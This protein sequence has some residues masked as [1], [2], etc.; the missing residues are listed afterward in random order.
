[1]DIN[2]RLQIVKRLLKKYHPDLCPNPTLVDEYTAV[3]RRLLKV[4][5]ELEEEER[6]SRTEKSALGKNDNKADQAYHCYKLGVQSLRVVHPGRFY[7]TSSVGA[8]T[9]IGS[10]AQAKVVLEI[11]SAIEESIFFFTQVLQCFPESAWSSDSREKL[12]LLAKL[13]R[14]YK[15][16]RPSDDGRVLDMEEFMSRNGVRMV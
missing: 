5:E 11:L 13:K 15:E 10:E 6:G 9:R 8:Q 3:S 2:D 1:M 12:L 16:Y 7:E 14:R 4:K